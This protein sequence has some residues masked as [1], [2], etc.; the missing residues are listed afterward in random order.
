MSVL[1]PPPPRSAGSAGN[2]SSVSGKKSM[3]DP[4]FFAIPLGQF[5]KGGRC[6]VTLAAGGGGG[7]RLGVAQCNTSTPATA[8][9]VES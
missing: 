8:A 6:H 3:D 5:S 4:L 1:A 9:G 2:M 7:F